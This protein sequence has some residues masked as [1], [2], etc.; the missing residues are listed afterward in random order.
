MAS[1]N[2]AGVSDTAA[3]SAKDDAEDAVT[4]ASNHAALALYNSWGTIEDHDY[5]FLTYG[6]W[7]EYQVWKHNDDYVALDLID[8]SR[9]PTDELYYQGVKYTAGDNGAECQRLKMNTNICHGSGKFVKDGVDWYVFI[10]KGRVF[11]V[12][13][14]TD[15]EDLVYFC[16][17]DS[18]DTI[19]GPYSSAGK[20]VG[21]ELPKQN[22]L[23]N[24]GDLVGKSDDVDTD[25][26]KGV[27]FEKPASFPLT[28]SA[29]SNVCA[30][31]DSKDV[32]GIATEYTDYCS[33]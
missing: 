31:F 4:N 26:V 21:A 29:L 3:V 33:A 19:H 2:T 20:S 27:F 15:P 8:S 16:H 1:G 9:Q 30:Y 25:G 5:N 6:I 28:I 18:C 22:Y 10:H 11:R 23:Y 12:Y 7:G 14:N 17:D 13:E 24:D 32:D